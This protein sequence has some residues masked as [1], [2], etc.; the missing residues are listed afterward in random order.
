ML[1]VLSAILHKLTHNAPHKGLS[2]AK[3]SAKR[4]P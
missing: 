1:P 2:E 4:E 3:S